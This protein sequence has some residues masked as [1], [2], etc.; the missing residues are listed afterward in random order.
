M[1]NEPRTLVQLTERVTAMNKSFLVSAML[2]LAASFPLLAEASTITLDFKGPG[3]SSRIELTYGTATDVRYPQGFE[4]TGI[5][6]TYSYT[7]NS[8]SIVNAAIESIVPVT[9]EAPPAENLDAANDFSR[10][11]VATGLPEFTNGFITYDNLVY[12]GGST[13]TGGPLDPLGLLFNI[14]G[15]K[16]VTLWP[17]EG[18]SVTGTGDYSVV[19]AT[20]DTF[21]SY[22][23]GTL[24]TVPEPST[25][26]LMLAG[27]GLCGLMVR[28]RARN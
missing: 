17:N 7:N 2:S 21:L 1:P 14:A 24:T 10:F 20:R 18:V 22:A 9:R 11:A 16:V 8:L 26:A 23:E 4:I 13:Q 19:V 5:S 25:Y 27:L 3:V 12:P 28:H 6:G 15:G